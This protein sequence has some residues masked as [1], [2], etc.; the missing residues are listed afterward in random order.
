VIEGEKYGIPQT[1]HRV[2]LLGLRDDVSAQ[3]SLLIPV[4]KPVKAGEVL[5]GLPRLRS[6]FSH[7]DDNQQRWL[8]MLNRIREMP[9]LEQV[10]LKAGDTVLDLMLRKAEEVRAPRHDRG[11]E[12]L[13]CSVKVNYREDW[14]LDARIGGVCN[15]A[16]RAHIEED[17][18]R[19]FYVACFAEVH[20]SSPRLSN[21]PEAL[22]PDHQNVRRSLGHGNF[23]DRFRV[24]VKGSPST[25]VVSHIAKDGH[26]YIHYDPTQCRSLTVREAARL[27]TFPDN[28]FFCGNRT[29]QY[30]Q[31]GNAVPPLLAS[32]IAGI[33]YEVLAEGQRYGRQAYA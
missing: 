15:S 1:R 3:P 12:F 9:W 17:L 30:T 31:V 18:Y 14:Y 7:G 5:E 19:Y 29:E 27:Q 21:F 8:S 32:Q 26:Y 2:I 24:Q 13:E 22:Y 6:G 20:G 33:V 10:R 4:G 28:Y 25:T 11:G 16:T 23:G